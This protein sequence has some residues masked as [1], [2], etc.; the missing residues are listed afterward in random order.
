MCE[1]LLILKLEAIMDTFTID[2][3]TDAEK[4]RARKILTL[5]SQIKRRRINAFSLSAFLT[6]LL[7][8]G[9]LY[10]DMILLTRNISFFGATG[11]RFNSAANIF[12]FFASALIFAVGVSFPLYYAIFLP[13]ARLRVLKL[14]E[15]SRRESQE[16][17]LFEKL[18][19]IRALT[20]IVPL[21]EIDALSN[22]NLQ[23]KTLDFFLANAIRTININT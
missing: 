21:D 3:L 2:L 19:K 18:K 14:K 11:L 16:D 23:K 22:S 17:V 15:L 10:A 8:I 4:H 20:D 1:Y 9:I 5:V 6:M 12:W 7:A 13:R